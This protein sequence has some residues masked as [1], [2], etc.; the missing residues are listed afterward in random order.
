MNKSLGIITDEVSSHL[1]E[2]L[3]FAVI[4]ELAHIEIRTVEGINVLMLDDHEIAS[5]K[6]AVDR[7]GLYV[8]CLTSPI[9]KC[10]LDPNRRVEVGDTFGFQ[11]ESIEDHFQLLHRA[12]TIA[13]QLGTK[14]IRVFSFWREEDP[15]KYESE[16]AEYLWQ[17]GSLAMKEGITL[18]LENEP[19]CN[20][21]FATE[22]GRLVRMV[23]LDGLKVLW[24]PGNEAY[25]GRSAYPEGY[26]EIRGL[27]RHVHIKDAHILNGHPKCVPI[28]DG[29]VPFQEQIQALSQ[30]GYDGLFSIET[31]YVPV[32]GTPL[33]GSAMSIAGLR[34][35]NLG[36]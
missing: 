2:A 34:R 10:A 29:V 6:Q 25:G 18:L 35:L 19:A 16:I 36:F 13:R 12:F 20:G 32:G 4:H 14:N 30:D 22:I 31:H 15:E 8:S 7:Q 1:L 27:V 11:K 23:N 21:G 9:F 24:D 17:A 5:V 33:D 26:E 3:D 28:G